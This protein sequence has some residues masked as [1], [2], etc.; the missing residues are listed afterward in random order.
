[1]SLL[2]NDIVI[3][4]VVALLDMS[5]ISCCHLYS[6]IL[7]AAAI[8]MDFSSTGGAFNSDRSA[9]S[10]WLTSIS[11]DWHLD[12]KDDEGLP[13]GKDVDNLLSDED[14]SQ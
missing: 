12:E 7:Y 13:A 10:S 2:S 6:D 5:C 8:K 4:A 9:V 3:F 14:K 11:N 1:M